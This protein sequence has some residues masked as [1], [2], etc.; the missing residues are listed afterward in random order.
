MEVSKE[1][2]A[3]KGQEDVDAVE[4]IDAKDILKAVHTF[5]EE[6]KWQ[7]WEDFY[8]LWRRR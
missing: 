4:A 8:E 7:T 1:E 6:L 2:D 3:H 5:G